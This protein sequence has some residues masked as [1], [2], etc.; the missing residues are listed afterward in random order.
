MSDLYGKI[1]MYTNIYS[2]MHIHI[3]TYIH[4]YIYIYTYI[5]IYIASSEARG[6]PALYEKKIILK[7]EKKRKRTNAYVHVYRYV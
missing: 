4:M 1:Y 3:Y 7:M 2:Y 6:K 5:Y